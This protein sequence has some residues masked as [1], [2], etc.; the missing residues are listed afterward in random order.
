[1]RATIVRFDARGRPRR[2]SR[3][4]SRRSTA[5]VYRLSSAADHSLLWHLCGAA[6][7]DRTRRRSSQ[8]RGAL[9][10]RDG[11]RVAAHQRRGQ[12]RVRTGPARRRTKTS[13]SRHGLHRPITSSF[14]SGHATAAFCAAT[15]ARRRARLVRARG[16]GRGDPGLRPPAPRLR[17]RRRRRLRPRARESRSADSCGSGGRLAFRADAG[18]DVRAAPV[19]S[20][21]ASL[22]GP[23]T[24]QFAVSFDYRCPF[25]RNGHES[26]VAG[27]RAGRD[28]DVRF[29]PFSLDQVHVEEGEPPVWERDPDEWG[30][31][32]LAL[33]LG[34]RGARL[35]PRPLPRL[36]HRRVRGPP[37][38]GRQDRQ[39]RSAARDRDVGR[40][41]RRRGRGRGRVGPA[42]QGPRRR[43]HRSRSSAG[44]V[45]GVPTFIVGERAVF[46]RVMD[47]NNPDDVDRVLDLLEW[48]DLNEFKH[49]S[50]PA[51]AT[52]RRR[53][54]P[55]DPISAPD[56]HACGVTGS[57]ARAALRSCTARAD[58][59]YRSDHVGGREG[60][61]APL[62]LLQPDDPRTVARRR[63]ACSTRWRAR[64]AAI[65]RL[66]PA[67]RRRAAAHRAARV[68]RRP[69][70]R[71]LRARPPGRAP[72]RRQRARA[73]RPLRRARRTTA[74]PGA[75]AVGVHAHRGT[76]RRTRRAAP[77]GPPHDHR[78]RRRAAALARVRRLRARRRAGHRRR[79]RR[80]PTPSTDGPHDT[81]LQRRRARAVADATVRDVARRAAACSAAPARCSPTRPE[82]PARAADA[83]R[84]VA[85]AAAP[86]AQ[87]RARP[88]RRDARPVA[89]PPL[90][91]RTR[92]RSRRCRA[93][94]GS[95]A[96]A[97]TTLYVTGL[98][99]A[100][101]RYHERLGSDVDELRLAMPISTRDRGDDAANRFVPARRRR[102]D[103]TR[104]RSAGAVRP[105]CTSALGRREGRG[106][107]RRRREPRRRC[108]PACPPSFLVAMTRAQTRTT[109]FAATNLRGSPV[110]L[111]IAGARV[112]ASYPF[113][114]R[115]GTA[116][117]VTRA[118]LLR[119]PAPRVEHRSRRPITDVDGVHERRRRRR[120]TRLLALRVA[121]VTATAT[122]GPSPS[123]T[124]SHSAKQRV[125][126]AR[127]AG[128]RSSRSI[129]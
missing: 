65:P 48:T 50:V 74:R 21:T 117:N 71:P 106:R 94:P 27:L 95:S 40:A 18:N 89:R 32:V 87:H 60:P 75:S 70:A 38:R 62:R 80:R 101:G 109:D 85:L 72:G 113:G 43:A 52:G 56:A 96:G 99:G 51:S 93:P 88:L 26:V 53:T 104:R 2:R 45:F 79:R 84:L 28:W 10:G 73:A 12:D 118:E 68:R 19:G 30:T 83:A 129:T 16:R 92:S 63:A 112:I 14:P 35:V 81:P 49:T 67:R 1:M 47:R 82:L 123:I 22:G 31:G 110:P 58:V 107:D 54:T 69:D 98:A 4:Q 17:R 128:S 11:R 86:G 102:A 37:R 97:S 119:R 120:S 13:S 29:L 59:G 78:R 39:G 36:A 114:P 33:L 42:A 34:H 46:V 111:Y 127:G 3:A 15:T 77:E 6:T 103:P 115:T 41:R 108:S 55:S 122:R 8:L 57:R 116:L 121:C 20:K 25:A 100:L 76:R 7:R 124:S 90:R 44:S 91:D 23:V 9:R 105:T 5:I 125:A 66:R 64:V 126:P 24:R 61:R